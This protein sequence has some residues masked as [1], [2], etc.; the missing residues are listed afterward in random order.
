MYILVRKN[1]RILSIRK[2]WRKHPNEDFL[3]VLLISV[4]YKYKQKTLKLQYS[5]SPISI[6]NNT[7]SQQAAAFYILVHI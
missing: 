3:F 1:A 7:A 2:K 6:A 4:L 5:R